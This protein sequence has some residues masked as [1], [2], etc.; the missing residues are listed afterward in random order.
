MNKPEFKN[1]FI[2][3]RIVEKYKIWI[4][5][6][7]VIIVL[8]CAAFGIY[9]GVY[10]DAGQGVNVG[11]DFTG[12]AMITVVLGDEATNN[13]DQH[14]KTISDVVSK[15]GAQ[16]SYTQLSGEGA[17]ASVIVRYGLK[18][19][20]V[21][22]AIKTELMG[23]YDKDGAEESIVNV[24]AIGAT[25]SSNL[26]LTAVLSVLLS[27]LLILIYIVIRFKNV[28]TGLAA[29]IALLHDVIIV[30]ALTVICHIQI[31]SSFIAAIITIIAYSINNTIVLFDR[32]RD[33]QRHWD[34]VK[35]INHNEITNK[36][37]AQTVT[38]SINT[39]ITT[40]F[41]IVILAII[42]VSSIKEFAL[43]VIFGL[44]CGTYSSIFLA[45][46]LYCLMRNSADKRTKRNK[47]NQPI[48]KKEKSKKTSKAEA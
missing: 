33:N 37:I 3:K 44:I 16:V 9:A 24:K 30:V 34:T 7:I 22:Q 48:E 36:S 8:A 45:P 2:G 26:V 15:H 12:G 41:A 5:V 17:E 11:I 32:V 39:T 19:N 21:D 18:S 25:A 13:F 4:L 46:S 29:V 1:P 43:P 10:K 31:N 23:I 20:E 35:A 40:L 6:P 14:V 47:L 28:Y 42:G 38:R 27:T